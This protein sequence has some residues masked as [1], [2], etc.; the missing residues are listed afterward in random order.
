MWRAVCS[1]IALQLRYVHELADHYTLDASNVDGFEI[2]FSE[3]AISF[4]DLSWYLNYLAT[5][6]GHEIRLIAYSLLQACVGSASN[7]FWNLCPWLC[8]LVN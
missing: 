4:V 2:S 7:R 1:C 5:H 8:W 6:S 3:L